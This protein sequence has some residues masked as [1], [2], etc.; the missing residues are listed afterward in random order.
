MPDALLS[1]APNLLGTD[2]GKMSKSRG[3]AISLSAT[4][5]QTARLI[6][7]AKTD[8]RRH[9]SYE[10]DARPEV[11]SLVLLAALCQGRDP[12]RSPRRSA[13]GGAGRLKRVVTESVNEFLR[14]IRA[15]RAEL[16]ADPGYLAGARGRERQGRGDRRRY[17]CRGQGRDGDPLLT[18]RAGRASRDLPR[19]GVAALAWTVG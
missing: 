4:A 14:P 11:S 5:D 1:A 18:A 13:A 9:I 12:A 19:T 3:N 10:P 6:R 16:A 15:R 8:A 2:G 17:A 7:R